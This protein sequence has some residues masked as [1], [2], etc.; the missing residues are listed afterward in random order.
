M[1]N[2]REVAEWVATAVQRSIEDQGRSKKSVADETGIPH[3]T[4]Y[5]KV[6]G[7]GEFR[8]SELLAIADT[9]GVP[10]QTFVPPAFAGARAAA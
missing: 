4:F 10:P 6:A 3:P 7:H 9:L 5:R 1:N 2:S 8:L